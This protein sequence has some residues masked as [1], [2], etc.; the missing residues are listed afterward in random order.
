MKL[1]NEIKNIAIFGANSHIAKNLIDQFLNNTS[2]KL[3]LFSRNKSNL[4]SFVSNVTSDN[5]TSNDNHILHTSYENLNSQSFDVIINCI[6]ITNPSDIKKYGNK[7]LPL[8]KKYDDLIIEYL[9]KNIFCKYFNFSS[10]IVYGNFSQPL[11]E[12]LLSNSIS[13]DLLHNEY[14]L[15][16]IY[17]EKKHRLLTSLNIIDIRIFGFFSKFINLNADFFISKIIKSINNDEEFF[18]NKQNFFRD[19]INPQDLFQLIY[20][21]M[22]NPKSN[23]AIDAYS[24]SP[25][26]KY[27]ILQEF[28]NH[29]NL[30]YSFKDNLKINESTEFKKYYY[31]LSRKIKNIGYSP[32]YSSLETLLDE[33][34]PLIK[35]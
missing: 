35:L 14:Y 19:F 22:K 20:A 25:I 12:E 21:C 18:T 32:I 4:Q 3:F 11:N 6:G 7:I 5:N 30:K 15:T 29:Y 8:S 24:R 9:Q 1:S 16:K 26:S 27:D 2:H 13:N 28:V 34:A 31:S 33:S 23:F 17:L 10:G